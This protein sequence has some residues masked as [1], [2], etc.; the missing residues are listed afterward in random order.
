M[1][2]SAGGLIRGRGGLYAGQKK[3]SETTDMIRQNENLYLKK[4][5]KI[6]R[7]IRLFTHQRK[8]VPEIVPLWLKNR[9]QFVHT[10]G[11]MP[12]GTYMRRGY[13]WSNT[14]V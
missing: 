7:I 6:C 10:G 3:A 11:L 5:K 12:W 1:D 9:N 14:S 4:M 2:L 13:A 8:F